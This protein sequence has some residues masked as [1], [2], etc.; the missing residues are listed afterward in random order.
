MRLLSA[1][2]NFTA[3]DAPDWEGFEIDIFQ[4]PYVNGPAVERQQT[5]FQFMWRRIARTAERKDAACWAKVI[6]RGS[7]S[8]LITSEIFP[9]SQQSKAFS[10]NAMNERASATTDRTVAHANG[11]DL[12]VDFE[13]D[14][15]AMAAPA[16]RFHGG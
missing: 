13:L 4:A 3:L 7:R 2:L 1:K 12:G 10:G 15:P 8:P 14:L 6:H 5:F 16:V 11:I 9:W